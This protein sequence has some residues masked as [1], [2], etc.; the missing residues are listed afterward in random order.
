M[1]L[2]TFFVCVTYNLNAFTN[3]VFVTLNF[4]M[5]TNFVA[6]TFK[7]P[8]QNLF[9]T[10][11][12]PL[13]VLI[14]TLTFNMSLQIHLSL[15][16]LYKR[17]FSF[18]SAK[19]KKKQLFFLIVNGCFFFIFLFSLKLTLFSYFTFEIF[20]RFVRRSISVNSSFFFHM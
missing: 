3:I 6:L 5:T 16:C 2:Q 8:L 14:V 17:P 1:P 19:V 4:K 20:A 7:M 15:T 13:Q 10:L 12:M 9:V 18:V 11:N